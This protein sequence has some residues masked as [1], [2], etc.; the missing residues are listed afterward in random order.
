M[1]MLGVA[2]ALLILVL[3]QGSANRAD[4]S[5]TNASDLS[6]IDHLVEEREATLQRLA[7]EA[8]FIS[9]RAGEPRRS[10]AGEGEDNPTS[11][12]MDCWIVQLHRDFYHRGRSESRVRER[13]VFRRVLHQTRR[14]ELLEG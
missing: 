2:F 10:F 1:L 7:A 6:A 5:D 12:T 8:V 11:K 9:S 14:V 3:A 4:G 13:N